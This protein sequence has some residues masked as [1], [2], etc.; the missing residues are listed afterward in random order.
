MQNVSTLLDLIFK[1]KENSIKFWFS[2]SN[3]LQKDNNEIINFCNI[4]KDKINSGNQQDILLSLNLIDLA[5]DLDKI[6]L[7]EKIDSKNFISCLVNILKNNNDPDIQSICRYLIKKLRDKFKN[8]PSLKN[9]SNIFQ[10]LQKS[11]INIPNSIK[12]SYIN[13]PK[14]TN[15]NNHHLK[16]N[17]YD[18]IIN[19]NN[20]NNNNKQNNNY[21]TQIKDLRKS[22][23]PTNPENYLSIINLN[24]KNFHPKYQKFINNL[25]ELAK[26]IGAVNILIN[27]NINCKNNNKIQKLYDYLKKGWKQLIEIVD[28]QNFEDNNLMN[29]CLCIIEDLNMTFQ[30]AKKS[31]KGENPGE[32]LTS[33][34]RDNNPYYNQKKININKT[35]NLGENHKKKFD[36]I[37]LG[38]TTKTIFLDDGE[39]NNLKNSLNI[40]FGSIQKSEI[41]NSNE[42]QITNNKNNES[43]HV[44][45]SMSQFSD[46]GDE[47]NNNINNNNIK[48]LIGKNKYIFNNSNVMIIGNKIINNKGNINN[49]LNNNNLTNINHFGNKGSKDIYNNFLLNNQN[50]QPNKTSINSNMINKN[51]NINTNYNKINNNKINNKNNIYNANNFSNNRNNPKNRNN[52]NNPYNNENFLSKTQYVIKHAN[53]NN[54]NK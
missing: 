18:N 41:K 27:N 24:Q 28:V 36:D 7:W 1:D 2:L 48:N 39:N 4:I 33:F 46:D 50:F 43:M 14:N 23:L 35:I 31:M 51:M 21:N 3:I 42:I 16:N 40:M 54:L 19:N 32:F 52:F 44:F 6:V 10:N 12:H 20:D 26:K 5:V 13:I 53:F 25:I 38:N 11:G 34:T 49:N 22:R 17:G 8:Y 30:R 37:N 29:I 47:I 15:L 45:N 9:C